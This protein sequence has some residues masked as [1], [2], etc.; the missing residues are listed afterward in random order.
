MGDS[1]NFSEESNGLHHYLAFIVIA[2]P[3]EIYY[4]QVQSKI[5]FLTALLNLFYTQINEYTYE[6]YTLIHIYYA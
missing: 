4:M 2:V 5:T 6:V 1:S 3:F